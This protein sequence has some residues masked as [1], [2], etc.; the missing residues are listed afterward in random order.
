MKQAPYD[1]TVGFLPLF[2]ARL[3]TFCGT[4]C[5]QFL[6]PTLGRPDALRG[7]CVNRF[8]IDSTVVNAERRRDRLRVLQMAAFADGI[9]VFNRWEQGS[10]HNI[11]SDVGFGL[12]LWRPV[13]GCVQFRN[14]LRR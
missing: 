8:C 14:R 1:E 2:V 13:Q 10:F 12:R 7:H 11:Q 9:I 6:R 5:Q 3:T 4:N